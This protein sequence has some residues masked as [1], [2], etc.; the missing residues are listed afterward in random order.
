MRQED[1]E[2]VDQCVTRLRRK[3]G[4]C[5]FKENRNEQIRDQMFGKCRSSKPRRKFVEKR[6]KFNSG[7]G[8]ADRSL[9]GGSGDQAKKM[10]SKT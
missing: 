6:P 1:S 9:I 8:S 5:N 2:T 7:K 3:T 10:G 4:N